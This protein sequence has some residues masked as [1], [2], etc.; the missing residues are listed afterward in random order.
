MQPG[1]RCL[2]AI[3]VLMLTVASC[4]GAGQGREPF[5]AFS[6]DSYWNTPLPASAPIHPSS[7]D[8]IAYLRRTN[9]QDGCVLLAGAGTTPDWGMP[10]YWAAPG[11]PVY[12]VQATGG[13]ELPPELGRLRVPRGA[14]QAP[15]SDAAMVVFDR[16][17]GWVVSLFEAR[18]EA[19][20]D[21]WYARGGTV[22]YLASNGLQGEWPQADELRN[23]G[24]HRGLNGAVMSVRHDEIAAGL[25]PHAL[26]IGVNLAAQDAVFPM[27]GS[28]GRSRDPHAPVQGGRLRI[29]PDVNLDAFNLQPAAR[30]IAQSLQTYGVVVGDSTGGGINLKVENTVAEGRGQLWNLDREA[31]CAIPIEAFEVIAYGWSDQAQTAR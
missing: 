13:V 26:K 4:W 5:Q 28:D 30:V 23:R 25:I 27:L 11:D 12:R 18:Y 21:T 10:I 1:Q 16:D 2:L 14:R 7:D 6:P 29:R 22:F 19:E 3:A 17:A 24:T 20:S 15:T 9:D 31:L 8:I